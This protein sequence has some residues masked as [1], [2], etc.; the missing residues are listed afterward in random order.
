MKEER[1]IEKRVKKKFRQQSEANEIFRKIL[2]KE[3]KGLTI[4]GVEKSAKVF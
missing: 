4:T 3:Q 1:N 2:S